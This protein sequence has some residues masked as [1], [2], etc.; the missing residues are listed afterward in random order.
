MPGASRES[1]PNRGVVRRAVYC[2]ESGISGDHRFYGF[3][4]LIMGYQ[5]RGELSATVAELKRYHRAPD[6]EIKWQHLRAKTYPFYAA[7]VDFF[8]GEPSMFF[9]CIVVERSWVNTKLYHG[10]SFDLARRKH[11]TQFLSN[12]IARMKR[13]HRGRQL[14]VR[15]YLDRIPSSYAKAGEAMEVIGNRTVNKLT[16]LADFAESVN[17][18]N[19]LTECDSHDYLGIQVCDLLL[20][21]V[22]D[23]WNERS[24]NEFKA[25]LKVRLAEHLGWP[26]LRSDT[27]PAE[28][29][30]NI[31]RLT[32]QVGKDQVRPVETRAVKLKKPLPLPRHVPPGQRTAG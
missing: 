10:G 14:E 7:L 19:A 18:I 31:W 32:D 15:V 6:G 8:F 5:R 3:G 26:D 9:H 25:K 24:T 20:G 23:T 22:V 21:A 17:T 28:R 1:L 27:I 16:P 2:D 12:K 4:A 30:F 11:F 29:K 13:V